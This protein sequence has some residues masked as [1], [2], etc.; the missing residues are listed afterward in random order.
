MQASLKLLSPVYANACHVVDALKETLLVVNENPQNV[1]RARFRL[2]IFPM[3]QSS[4]AALS[5]SIL[6]NARHFFPYLRFDF[7]AWAVGS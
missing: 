6:A 3:L 7:R 2:H 5:C 1:A 4:I